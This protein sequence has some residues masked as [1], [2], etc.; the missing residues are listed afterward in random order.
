MIRKTVLYVILLAAFT[1]LNLF[2]QGL[3]GSYNV[4]NGQTYNSLTR[5]NGFFAD[6]NTRGLNGNVTIYIT[7][8][9]N[10]D[11]TTALNQWAGNYTITI[12]PSNANEKNISAN[13]DSVLIRFNGA[14][15]VTIDGRYSGSG[16]YLKFRNTNG[17]NPA[18]SFTNDATYNTI[19][20]CT[21]ESN[22]S[23]TSSA[24]QA[25]TIIFGNTT[26]TTGNDFNTISYC[27]IRDRSDAAGYPAYAIY[28]SGSFTS[29]KYN[30]ENN[31]L[32]NN[33]YNFW[34]DGAICS[35]VSLNSGTGNNWVI[36]G[37]SFYQTSARNFVSASVSG[38]N[39][40]FVN[41]TAINNTAISSNYIGG[42]SALCNG[43]PWTAASVT[44]SI[45]FSGIR[46]AVGSGTT[47]SVDGNRISNISINTATT[48]DGEL[49]FSGI[50]CQSGLIN[51]GAASANII[52]NNTSTGNIAITYNGTLAN[53]Q[54][55]RG[56]DHR[57]SG[58]IIN[59]T[60]GSFSISGTILDSVIFDGIYRAGSPSGTTYITNNSIGSPTTANSIR[61]LS[62]ALIVLLNG[63]EVNL[64]GSSNLS[65]T[66]NTT[67]NINNASTSDG[68]KIRGIYLLRG[69]TP[70]ADISNN[71][72]CNLSASSVT[73]NVQP[74]ICAAIG[75][76][77]GSTSASQTI[78][79]NTVYAIR[80][81]ANSNTCVTGIAHT[82]QT[83][84]GTISRNRIFDLTNS[85]TSGAPSIY[86]IDAY[87]GNWIY[88][89]NQITLTNGEI[90]DN[91]NLEQLSQ[92]NKNKSKYELTTSL[93][94][95][96]TIRTYLEI[97]TDNL[98]VPGYTG[99]QTDENFD[100]STNGTIIRG[101][102]DEAGVGT[103]LYFNSI[104]IGGN[105][106]SGNANSYAYVRTA[107][108]VP[109]LRSN[110]FYNARTGG[111]GYH[112]AIAN[113]VN[114]PSNNWNSTASNYNLFISQNVNA[115]C[116]WGPGVL[117]T[118]DQWRT[119]STGDMQTWSLGAGSVNPANLFTGIS[120]GNLN[121]NSASQEAWYVNGKGTQVAS[122]TTDYSGN[123]RSNIQ[124]SGVPDIGSSEII[125]VS[126][127]VSTQQVG[128]IGPNQTTYYTFGNRTICAIKW[129]N[130]GALPNSVDVEYYSGVDPLNR[131]IGSLYS[132]AYWVINSNGGSG[133]E[134]DLTIYYDAAI[135]GTIT[136][137]SNIRIA[138]TN[139]SGNT[140]IPYLEQG[141]GT[142]QYELNTA[143][144]TIVIHGITTFTSYT[145]TDNTFPLPVNIESFNAE[146]TGRD[147]QL[148]WVT[149]SEIN[150]KGFDIERKVINKNDPN[151]QWV[152]AGFIEGAGNSNSRVHYEYNDTRLNS[153]EYKYRIKQ[154]DYNGYFEYFE[155]RSPEIISIG[156]PS[157]FIMCQNYP[158]PSNPVS[159]IDYEI[160]AA[161]KVS[162]KVYDLTGREVAS[163]VDKEMEA[164]YHTAV[165][166]GMNLSSGIYFY[167]INFTSP[168]ES[169]VKTMKL[170]LIK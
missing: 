74:N 43:T 50:L 21:I 15:R 55:I 116:E 163:L 49:T 7:S 148:T 73:A 33:I 61:V 169:F 144:K 86:G 45:Q 62:P 133:H 157:T 165:F 53:S 68:S 26:G 5:Q 9:L 13:S 114:P 76:M 75:I 100:Y 117:R 69:T 54:I 64:S 52:G 153:A 168:N 91:F 29:S 154:I 159:N 110:I 123:T 167:R 142:G 3:S 87:W 155:L 47:T 37:N 115:V 71:I 158:N 80:S 89:N 70:V 162:L 60:I 107:S 118:I 166:N 20:Y 130:H 2:A 63:I 38:W 95:K 92:E 59:N 138:K 161:G 40:I 56:I 28:S 93:P 127:P 109:E 104:Y 149:T 98:S 125:P 11:G 164:G 152:K 51:I 58:S 137:E 106:S 14:D 65:I 44:Y 112:F 8:N 78:S 77:S 160:P 18:F 90:T 23:N 32:Y 48:T 151:P 124:T 31:I 94:D 132:N 42:S 122:V 129:G 119:S 27:D 131:I 34:K 46:T 146:I 140:W 121:I 141:T 88:V 108:T 150:N 79:N 4:G 35:G 120:T 145:L 102:N 25:G 6:V 19:T 111:T 170:V 83:S 67:A 147:V 103:H 101:F 36:S 66:G 128:T 105:A 135:L 72:I 97:I 10:E 156:T 39:V 143:N 126:E 99:K 96:G 85:S 41:S 57:S 1:N 22:N 12:L 84:T 17:S 136:G 113:E 16:K 30:S 82:E 81:T 24:T 134:Y 139:N